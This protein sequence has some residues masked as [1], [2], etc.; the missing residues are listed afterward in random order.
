MKQQIISLGKD[1]MIYG[2]GSVI[3]R[4]IGLFTLPLFTAYLK[5]KEYGVLAMLALLTMVAQPVFRLGLSAA[6]GPSYFERNNPLN[7][8]KAVW[9]VFA[10]NIVSSTLLVSIAWLFPVTLGQLVRLPAEYSPLVKLTL[11]GCALTIMV[12]SFTQRVQFERQ[13]KLY[14]TATL[15]TALTAILV[16]VITVVF[17]G[18][19]VKGMVIGQLTGNTV[20]FLAFLLIGLKGTKPAVSA[21]MARE[22]LRQGLP[23]VPG[24]AFLFILMNCNKY[25]L[26]WQAGLGAVG[27]YSIGFNL[28]TAISIVTG[29]IASAWFPFFMT[30][31]E[32]QSEARVIFGR[33]LTYYVF[34]V[35]IICLLFFLLAKPA[36]LLLTKETFYDSYVVVG[37]VAFAY[38]LQT[39]FSFFLPGIHF[40]REIGYVSFVQGLAALLSLPINYFLIV[41]LG[42][43]GAAIGLAASNLLMTSLMYGWNYLHRTAYPVIKYEWGRIGLFAVIFVAILIVDKIVTTNSI[44]YDI[45]KAVVLLIIALCLTFMLLSSSERNFVYQFKK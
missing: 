29:G 38:F 6:M 11:T 40:N 7:K 35:G 28:G 3:T 23:L 8:S 4:F 22:L 45:S 13:A 30:Y 25:I 19:G 10:L 31:L 39:F 27:I 14:V 12:T 44:I 1:S 9:T 17:L 16:S 20:T 42:V 26:E 34:G 24:F 21:R 41:N 5:P 36:V 37:W 33:V 2:V 15:A 18:W 32:R 43:L